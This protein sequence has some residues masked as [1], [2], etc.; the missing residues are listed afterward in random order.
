M[1]VADYGRRI[2]L[3]GQHRPHA[4]DLNKA[5]LDTLLLN[6]VKPE[7]VVG[8]SPGSAPTWP[9]RPRH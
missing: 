6:T 4:V 8:K 5:A 3:L 9:L 1:H 2:P 7:A